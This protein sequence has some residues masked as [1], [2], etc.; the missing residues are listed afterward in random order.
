M[1]PVGRML[2]DARG[3]LWAMDFLASFDTVATWRVFDLEGRQL[4]VVRMPAALTVHEIGADW[5]LGVFRNEDDVEEVRAYAL[6]E[7]ARR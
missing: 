4:G 6:R 2:H 5:V 3:R 7:V 1:P